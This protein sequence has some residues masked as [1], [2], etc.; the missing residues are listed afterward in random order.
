MKVETEVLLSAYS[1]FMMT[2]KG[3]NEV[4]KVYEFLSGE[5]MTD[6]GMSLSFN[7][8]SEHLDNEYNLSRFFKGYTMPHQMA[9]IIN[10]AKVNLGEYVTLKEA[11]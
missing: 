8:W 3:F 2:T 9:E 4:K 10:I 5:L 1:G 6:T 11:H 7:K